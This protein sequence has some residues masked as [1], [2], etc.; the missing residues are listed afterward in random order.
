[1][2]L[3]I[4]F[5]F[6][7]KIIGYLVKSSKLRYDVFIIFLPFNFIYRK[8]KSYVLGINPLNFI[9]SIINSNT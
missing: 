2:V 1:M 9:S 7:R 5:F 8:N 6:S 3:L 4:L